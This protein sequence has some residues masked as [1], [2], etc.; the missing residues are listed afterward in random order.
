MHGLSIRAVN[1]YGLFRL[2]RS[3]LLSLRLS[4]VLLVLSG[5]QSHLLLELVYKLTDFINQVT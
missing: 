2:V 3:I 4:A 1:R 5:M